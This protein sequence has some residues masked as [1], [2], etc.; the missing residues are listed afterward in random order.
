[1]GRL[2][3][4]AMRLPA[5]VWGFQAVALASFAAAQPS[6]P[7]M[8]PVGG[9]DFDIQHPEPEPDPEPPKHCGLTS[10]CWKLTIMGAQHQ[11]Q[12]SVVVDHPCSHHEVQA[13]CLAIGVSCVVHRFVAGPGFAPAYLESLQS[14]GF[15]IL[16]L[17]SNR[18]YLT[19][20]GMLEQTPYGFC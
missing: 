9:D 11:W 8:R 17:Y 19:D 16:S 6:D 1:M 13:R 18:S 14:F 2:P 15:A 5:A 7:Q 4:R 3:D 12:M 10:D 20:A